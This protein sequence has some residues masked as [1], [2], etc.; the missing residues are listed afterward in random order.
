MPPVSRLGW[1]GPRPC[2]KARQDCKP[3]G[4]FPRPNLWSAGRLK[5][6]RAGGV[7]GLVRGF[8]FG[9]GS[10]FG[11]TGSGAELALDVFGVDPRPGLSKSG[12][13]SSVGRAWR[14]R[15]PT[16]CSAVADTSAT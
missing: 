1:Q 5:I 11:Q 3:H 10:G 7:I 14:E 12:Y 15:S 2:L 13:Q 8:V 6:T 16:S 4:G 9:L